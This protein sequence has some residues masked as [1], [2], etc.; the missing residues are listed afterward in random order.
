MELINQSHRYQTIH[1]K[2]QDLDRLPNT[3]CFFCPGQETS[4]LIVILEAIVGSQSKLPI[5]SPKCLL[6][7]N[8]RKLDSQVLL[9]NKLLSRP[10][11]ISKLLPVLEHLSHF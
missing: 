6:D 2:I 8:E 7:G 1:S 9:R 10:A 3:M 4:P 5:K 11:L